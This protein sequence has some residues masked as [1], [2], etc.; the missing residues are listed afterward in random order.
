MPRCP[1]IYASSVY[2]TVRPQSEFHEAMIYWAVDDGTRK[3]TESIYPNNS[4]SHIKHLAIG[5]EHLSLLTRHFE[6]VEAALLPLQADSTFSSHLLYPS[7]F[8]PFPLISTQLSLWDIYHL[9]FLLNT[10]II[11]AYF[12]AAA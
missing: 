11:P 12:E 1:C 5:P 8:L 4:K 7:L 2:T 9:T 3:R 6:R 10:S